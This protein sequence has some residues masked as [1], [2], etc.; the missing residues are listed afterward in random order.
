MLT[1][2]IPPHYIDKTELSLLLTLVTEK[3]MLTVVFF[4]KLWEGKAKPKIDL[5]M[6]RLG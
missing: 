2:E 1:P 5:S 6:W 3:T 4:S